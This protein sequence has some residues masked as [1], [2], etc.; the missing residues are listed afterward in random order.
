MYALNLP[1]SPERGK[2]WECADLLRV[3]AGETGMA[4]QTSDIRL[5][6][7]SDSIELDNDNGVTRRASENSPKILGESIPDRRDSNRVWPA[8]VKGGGQKTPTRGM[9]TRVTAMV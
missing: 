1:L 9:E 5:S 4:I 2:F 7:V 3:G 8:N 6:G